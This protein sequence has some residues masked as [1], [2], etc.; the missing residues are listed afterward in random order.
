MTSFMKAPPLLPPRGKR[1]KTGGTRDAAP[2]WN[3][4]RCRLAA[5]C[6]HFP[7]AVTGPHALKPVELANFR[8][9]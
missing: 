2:A 4:I 7:R 9:E 5:D 8:T 1:M 6:D 3:G